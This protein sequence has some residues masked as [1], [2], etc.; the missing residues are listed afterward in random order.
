MS[1]DP[2]A[3]SPAHPESEAV[4]EVVYD[5]GHRQGL[6]EY[7]A[8]EAEYT[9]WLNWPTRAKD[10]N[11]YVSRATYVQ[12]AKAVHPADAVRARTRRSRLVA[13]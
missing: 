5:A 3:L 8:T 12:P 1:T 13:R 6:V 10:P 9:A 4:L 2:A 11:F 7:M